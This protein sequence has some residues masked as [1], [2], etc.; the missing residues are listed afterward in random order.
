[1]ESLLNMF[2]LCLRKSRVIA[3]HY[4]TKE[5]LT[6]VKPGVKNILLIPLVN[7]D[8]VLMHCYISSFM[9]AMA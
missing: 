2:V 9:K 4:E 8:K 1:M 7:P 3:Q 6:R 5:W